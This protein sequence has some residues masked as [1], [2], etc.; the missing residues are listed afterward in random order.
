MST[1]FL[2]V[3]LR[4]PCREIHQ[5]QQTRSGVGVPRKRQELS[6]LL[7]WK[8]WVCT[9]FRWK[10]NCDG[11]GKKLNANE[12]GIPIWTVRCLNCR[13]GEQIG[14]TRILP[15]I[16]R[17]AQ[18]SR[19]QL[20]GW[21]KLLQWILLRDLILKHSSLCL[22][23]PMQHYKYLSTMWRTSETTVWGELEAL[24]GACKYYRSS[25]FCVEASSIFFFL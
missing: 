24:P 9:H 1:S 8:L 20:E 14:Q 25:I 13:L 2:K 6:S 12:L 23:F 5:R 22:Y 3:M 19:S 16:C 15:E 18:L 21:D 7:E 11:S 17:K 4:W 10:L